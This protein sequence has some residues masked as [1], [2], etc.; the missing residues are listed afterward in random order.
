MEDLNH[1]IRNAV[2]SIRQLT[3]NCSVGERLAI[4]KQLYRIEHALTAFEYRNDLLKIGYIEVLNLDKKL[5]EIVKDVRS[6]FGLSVVTSCYRPGDRGVHGQM[7]VRGIDLRCRMVSIGRCIERWVNSRWEYDPQRPHMKCA[8]YHDV[9]Y[10]IHLHLQSHP[11]TRKRY[12][13]RTCS[14]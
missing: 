5:E 9:G 1:E 12:D 14:R 11:N 3:K 2:V 10:G 7:P 8:L 6:K 13:D 4:K